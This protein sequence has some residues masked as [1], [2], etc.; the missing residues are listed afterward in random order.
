[1]NAINTNS[2][3][4]PTTNGAIFSVAHFHARNREGGTYR[5]AFAATLRAI[6]TI[7]KTFEAR[8]DCEPEDCEWSELCYF[9]N[10]ALD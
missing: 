7:L 8:F 10:T 9:L 2:T 1:M 4:K 3:L 5:A 6:T